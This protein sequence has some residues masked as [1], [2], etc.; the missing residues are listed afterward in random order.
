MTCFGLYLPLSR[1][2]LLTAHSLLALHLIIHV[3]EI[4]AMHWGCQFNIRSIG[5][6]LHHV[7]ECDKATLEPTVLGNSFGSVSSVL[8]LG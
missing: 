1:K 2:L 4:G 3:P 5:L 7:M 8:G 6:S